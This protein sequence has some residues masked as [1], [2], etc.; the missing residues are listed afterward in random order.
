M[1]QLEKL[2]NEI[3]NECDLVELDLNKKQNIVE[4]Q[5]PFC[6][7][8]IKLYEGNDNDY[9]GFCSYCSKRINIVDD[10]EFG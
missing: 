9:E 3:F 7:N 5:C 1:K 10:I 4:C 6:K 2:T 8:K